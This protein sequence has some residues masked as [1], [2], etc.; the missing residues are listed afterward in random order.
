MFVQFIG[1]FEGRDY[2]QDLTGG[3]VRY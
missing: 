3:M 2:F 1:G